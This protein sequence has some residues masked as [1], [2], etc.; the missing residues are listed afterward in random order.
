MFWEALEHALGRIPD[1]TVSRLDADRPV[2]DALAEECPVVLIAEGTPNDPS[3]HYQGLLDLCGGL[4]IVVIDPTGV[5]SI[6]RLRDI[7]FDVLLRLIRSVAAGFSTQGNDGALKLRVLKSSDVRRLALEERQAAKPVPDLATSRMYLEDVRAWLDVCLHQRLLVEAMDSEGTT[8]PGWAMS[9]GRARALLGGEYVSADFE[10]LRQVR[11]QCESKL[12]AREAADRLRGDL[13]KLICLAD[14]FRLGERDQRLLAFVLAPEL[15]GR[16]ARIYGFLNDDLTRRR[17][18]ASILAQLLIPDRGLAWDVQRMFSAPGPLAKYGLIQPDPHDS[19]PKSEVG[20]ALAPEV[21]FYLLAEDGRRPQYNKQI[22]FFDAWESDEPSGH[23]GTTDLI[24]KLAVWRE[25]RRFGGS[26]SVIQ[27]LGDVSARRW[28]IRAA[29][30]QGNPVVLLDFEGWTDRS[31]QELMDLALRGA[32]VAKMHDAILVL[33]G[34]DGLHTAAREQLEAALLDQLLG[35]TRR[36][37]VHGRSPWILPAANKVCLVERPPL[38]FHRRSE[39]WVEKAQRFDISLSER[40]ARM[41]A[42]TVAF[43][44]ED[45]DASLQLY[46]KPA[47]DKTPIDAIKAAARQVARTWLPNSVARLDPVFE[48]KDIVLPDNTL[49]LLRKIPEH[50]EHAGEVFEDW[51]FDARMPYGRGVAALFSGPSGTGK[52]MAARI[53]ARELGVELFQVDLA[54]TVSKYIGETEKNLDRVFE[55]AQRASAVLLIDEAD[56]LFGK[57]TEVKDAHDRYANV[58][59]AFL[60]QRMESYTGLAI[61]TT[62]LK[63]NLDDAFLRRLRFVIDFPAPKPAHRLEIWKRAFPDGCSVVDDK[64]LRFLAGRFELTGG[65]IQQIALRAAFSAASGGGLIR[66]EH[67]VTATRQE[68][69]K[70]GML[71]AERKLDERFAIKE[72]VAQS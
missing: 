33:S 5:D 28:F 19:G 38:S 8:T 65:H 11:E 7:G 12:G 49:D 23:L 13:P 31:T 43:D 61:L 30:S 58:E 72:R 20:L 59:V 21:I 14:A 4:S 24:E 27:L 39:L 35:R 37:V 6:L 60:L 62:N 3:T 1:F 42:A 55:A 34:T 18:T 50:V 10:T 17:P 2:E 56:A 47:S 63:R 48:W 29:T 46:S 44:E 16:Y 41:L 40:D 25:P 64:E 22:E 36:L 52:T 70:L 26:S 57:R 45:I 9:A 53:I 71:H 68:L 15:D 54:K 66:A 51:G 67:I 32:R 69:L